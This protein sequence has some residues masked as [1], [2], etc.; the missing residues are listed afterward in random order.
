M[1]NYSAFEVQQG[2]VLERVEAI[3]RHLTSGGSFTDATPISLTD[4]E[5][6]I[7]DSYYW[8]CGELAKNGYSLT[9]TDTEVKAVLGQIQALDAVAQ[10][11]FSQPVTVFLFYY[12]HCLRPWSF[13]QVQW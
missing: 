9:V 6:F 1:A 12:L 5:M 13:F 11:E 2:G 8:L 7:N 3:C 4:V 10:V